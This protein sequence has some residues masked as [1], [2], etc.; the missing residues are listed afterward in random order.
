[1]IEEQF[2]DRI[3][4]DDWV[5]VKECKDSLREYEH[6]DSSLECPNE[7]FIFNIGTGTAKSADNPEE[8]AEYP[9]KVPTALFLLIK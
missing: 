9:N 8:R 3:A 6:F 4:N 1:M 2:P 7:L 5:L